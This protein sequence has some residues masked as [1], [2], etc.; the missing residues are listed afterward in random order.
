MY[1]Q[2]NIRP[3]VS[4]GCD[5]YDLSLP[6]GIVWWSDEQLFR[7]DDIHLNGRDVMSISR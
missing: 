1:N 4:S 7:R 2:F 6:S 3:E 5:R